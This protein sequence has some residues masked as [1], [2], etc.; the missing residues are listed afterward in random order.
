MMRKTTSIG[1]AAIIRARMEGR[2]GGVVAKRK[3]RRRG[4]GSV[5]T[6]LVTY[7]S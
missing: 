6:R 7:R 4:V 1:V 5:S 2:C 3:R